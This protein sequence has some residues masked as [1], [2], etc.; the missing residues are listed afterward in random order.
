MDCHCYISRFFYDIP[1]FLRAFKWL[2]KSGVDFVH[3]L[4]QFWTMLIEETIFCNTG[5]ETHW[6]VVN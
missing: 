1:R 4:E 5:L 3:S 6:V 2:K